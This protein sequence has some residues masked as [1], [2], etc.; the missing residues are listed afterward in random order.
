MDDTL[1]RIC[2]PFNERDSTVYKSIGSHLHYAKNIMGHYPQFVYPE[3]TAHLNAALKLWHKLSVKKRL[4]DG[5]K[6]LCVGWD[7]KA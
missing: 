6:V 7:R 3:V 5:E 1:C 4:T 2:R